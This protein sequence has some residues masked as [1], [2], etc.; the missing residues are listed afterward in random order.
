MLRPDDAEA[1]LWRDE[2]VEVGGRVDVKF[3]D[4]GL[5]CA[6]REAIR[7]ALDRD[8]RLNATCVERRALVI[9]AGPS[10]FGSEVAVSTTDVSRWH[11]CPE[12]R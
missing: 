4:P 3:T 10:T 12:R 7:S 8:L 11:P 5:G 9:I 2:V 6:S 1:F